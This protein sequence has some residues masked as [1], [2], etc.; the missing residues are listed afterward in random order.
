MPAVTLLVCDVGHL[1]RIDL[2]TVDVL[3]R[4]AL[5]ARRRGCRF[6]VRDA[7]PDLRALLALAGLAEIL[8]CAPGSGV[9][10]ER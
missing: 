9:E 7:P 5:I 3:A 4:L 2:G 1:A 8:P 6:S 10:A